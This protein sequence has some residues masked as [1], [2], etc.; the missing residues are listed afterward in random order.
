MERPDKVFVCTLCGQ[1][2]PTL[3][4]TAERL[5]VPRRGLRSFTYRFI[6]GSIHH[7]RKVAAK[8]AGEK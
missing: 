4:T 3:P 5:T 8:A 2:W 6:D 1:H 7:L